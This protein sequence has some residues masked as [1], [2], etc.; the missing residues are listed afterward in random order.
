VIELSLSLVKYRL[1]CCSI[2]GSCW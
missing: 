1:T 2:V